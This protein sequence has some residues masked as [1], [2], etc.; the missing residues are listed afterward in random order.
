MKTEI[1]E[2]FFKAFEQSGV[3]DNCIDW[4]LRNV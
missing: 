1:E 4:M 2:V 3:V